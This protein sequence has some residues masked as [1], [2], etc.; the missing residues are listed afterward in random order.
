MAGAATA[1]ICPR[2]VVLVESG[3]LCSCQRPSTGGSLRVEI[4]RGEPLRD[5]VGEEDPTDNEDTGIAGPEREDEMPEVRKIQE[6]YWAAEK[7]PYTPAL[8]FSSGGD[9]IPRQCDYPVSDPIPMTV[10][11]PTIL[12]RR[13][14]T[15]R[16]R[17]HTHRQRPRG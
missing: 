17:R 7:K 6:N 13:P 3:G 2:L 12:Q 8:L 16:R 14:Q 4:R 9:S 1:A 11:L 5:K 15:P 10:Q